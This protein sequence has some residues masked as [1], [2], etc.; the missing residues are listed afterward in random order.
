M[1]P[2]ERRAQRPKACSVRPASGPERSGMPGPITGAMELL[3]DPLRSSDPLAGSSYRTIMLLGQ[4]N[5][6]L[7]LEAENIAL[8]SVVV[9]KLLREEL[10]RH[11][12]FVDRMRV[13]AQSLGALARLRHPNIVM[14]MDFAVTPSGVPFLVMERLHGRTVFEERRRRRA[15]PSDEAIDIARQTLAALAAVHSAGIVHR[16]IKASNLFLCEDPTS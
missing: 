7:V 3:P 12:E 2:K 13:E 16:D 6:A 10:A 4:G 15:L 9:V 8:G 1:T 11:P 14:V 5:M